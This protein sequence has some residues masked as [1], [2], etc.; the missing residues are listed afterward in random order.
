MHFLSVVGQV[1]AVELALELTAV[2]CL[3]KAVLYLLLDF[4]RPILQLCLITVNELQSWPTLFCPCVKLLLWDCVLVLIV[5][6]VCMYLGRRHS[7]CGTGG[8]CYTSS[9]LC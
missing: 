9:F 1:R 5:L 8:L 2:Q 3:I 7:I 6:T 4:L